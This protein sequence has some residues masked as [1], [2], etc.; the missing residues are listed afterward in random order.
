LQR[1]IPEKRDLYTHRREN[2][3]SQGVSLIWNYRSLYYPIRVKMRN[4]TDTV[5]LR[6]DIWSKNIRN[7]SHDVSCTWGA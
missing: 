3:E 4:H 7:T 1:Y 6:P 2:H 5:Q